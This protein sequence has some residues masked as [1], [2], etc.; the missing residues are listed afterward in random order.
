MSAPLPTTW[1]ATGPRF[2]AIVR[3]IKMLARCMYSLNHLKGGLFYK[4]LLKTVYFYEKIDL[5]LSYFS[6]FAPLTASSARLAT[7]TPKFEGT[8]KMLR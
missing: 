6:H 5:L 8:R 1:G 4:F 3:V 2:G 7:A